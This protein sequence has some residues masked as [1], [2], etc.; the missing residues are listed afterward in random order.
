MLV[1]VVQL[2]VFV[3][4]LRMGMRLA[5]ALFPALGTLFSLQ[6]CLIQ[7]LHKGVCL[8]LLYLVI[9]HLGDTPWRP[10]LF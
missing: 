5:L 3:G 7:P 6:C 2:G 4:P 9:V 8:V 10:A 1:V